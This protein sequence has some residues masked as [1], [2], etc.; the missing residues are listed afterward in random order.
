MERSQERREALMPARI[1]V[2]QAR[3]GGIFLPKKGGNKYR[4]KKRKV[5][6][7]TFDSIGESKRY[8]FLKLM[9]KRGVISDLKVHYKFEIKVEGEKVCSYEA[10]F[11]YYKHLDWIV[12]D[13][14]SDA[15]RTPL[16]RLK[17]KLMKAVFRIEIKEVSN[18]LEPIDE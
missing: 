8:G 9:E 10:D 6:G 11:T 4:A 12:E 13:F 1:S 16:Y 7:I 17:K 3:R 15:T 5:D 18:P 2:T 14:K